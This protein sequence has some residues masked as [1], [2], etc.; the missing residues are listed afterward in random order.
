M[1]FFKFNFWLSFLFLWVPLEP[2]WFKLIFDFLYFQPALMCMCAVCMC[3]HNSVHLSSWLL[4]QFP[5]PT[6]VPVWRKTT[7]DSLAPANLMSSGERFAST[8]KTALGICQVF[9]SLRPILSQIMGIAMLRICSCLDHSLTK[10]R[11]KYQVYRVCV[12][13]YLRKTLK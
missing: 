9:F 5:L 3:K 13:F 11:N 7:F 12:H 1:I 10:E 6:F 8:W 2:T 4:S